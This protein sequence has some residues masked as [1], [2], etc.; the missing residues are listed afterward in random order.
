MR[1]RQVGWVKRV[2]P[3]QPLLNCPYIPKKAPCWVLRDA[4]AALT[5][6]QPNLQLSSFLFGMTIKLNPNA[7]PSKNH[8]KTHPYPPKRSPPASSRNS[9][10]H[11]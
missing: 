3:G 2:K 11:V 8:V 4:Q 10:Y 6:P 1:M 7:L 5:L 9:P